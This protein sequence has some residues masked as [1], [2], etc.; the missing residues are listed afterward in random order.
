[1]SLSSGTGLAFHEHRNRT[2]ILAIPWWHVEDATRY[3]ALIAL[4]ANANP[5]RKVTITC[6]FCTHFVSYKLLDSEQKLKME[7]QENSQKI[8]Y[9]S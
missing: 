4:A 9:R 7:R 6:R 5:E 2:G 3:I 1:M 8:Q